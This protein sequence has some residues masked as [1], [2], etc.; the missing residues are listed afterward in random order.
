MGL[1]VSEVTYDLALQRFPEARKIIQAVQARKVDDPMLH[2]ALYELAFVANDYA[3]M[4]DQQHWFA[5]R[6]EYENTGL[7]LASDTEAYTG[8]IEKAQELTK[9]AVDSAIQADSKE[10]GAIFPANAAIRQAAFGNPSEARRATAEA[11]KLAPASPSVESEAA[12]A[13]AMAGDPVRADSLAED[14]RKRFPQNMQLQSLWLSAIH[15]QLALDRKNPAAALTALQTT[16]AIELGQIESVINISCLYPTYIRGEAYLKAG[17]GMQAAAEFRKILDHSG[18]VWNCWTGALAHLGVA[19]ANALEAKTSQG[20]DADAARVRARA[21]YKDFLALWK[22][23]DSEIPIYKQAKAE[24]A[25][26]Q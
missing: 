13:F 11:L 18:I 24:Y 4:E 5:S 2:A 1:Y 14:L 17:Q 16:E 21:A 9:R 10:A 15:A 20:A 26:M 3:A 22:D 23:A 12:R 25:K 19:R 8:Q 6:P 7:A